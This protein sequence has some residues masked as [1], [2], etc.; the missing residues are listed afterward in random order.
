MQEITNKLR[1]ALDKQIF[2]R[3]LAIDL[4]SDQISL[5]QK[6]ISML[7]GEYSLKPYGLV[8]TREISPKFLVVLEVIRHYNFKSV[9]NWCLGFTVLVSTKNTLNFLVLHL[10]I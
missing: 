2:K 7:G 8:Y 5:A 3:L 4:L 9:W 6:F 1:S 10:N